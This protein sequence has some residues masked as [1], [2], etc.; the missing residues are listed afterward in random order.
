MYPYAWL[1]SIQVKVRTQGRVLSMSIVVTVGVRD[2]GEG[3]IL[4]SDVGPAEGAH[5]SGL[6]FS[7]VL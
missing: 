4:G 6:L 5:H 2:D 3:E 1:D 7:E